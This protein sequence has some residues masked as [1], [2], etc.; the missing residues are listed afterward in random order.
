[1]YFFF[2]PHIHTEA[3]SDLRWM[4]FG[5]LLPVGGHG[6]V[7]LDVPVAFKVFLLQFSFLRCEVLHEC[8]NITIPIH[9]FFLFFISGRKDF[10]F[11]R[12]ECQLHLFL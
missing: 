12:H 4:A 6:S 7:L 11:K 5:F 3:E 9:F 10:I 2:L 1:M 8:F